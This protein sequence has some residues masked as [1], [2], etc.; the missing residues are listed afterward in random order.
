VVAQKQKEEGA[1]R[2]KLVLLG[3][4]GMVTFFAG[5]WVTTARGE[6]IEKDLASMCAALD[7]AYKKRSWGKD[8]CNQIEWIEGGKSVKGRPLIYA[9]FGPKDSKNV[10]LIL[11]MVHG[12]EITPLYIGFEMAAWAKKEMSRYPQARLI[13]APLVN[14]DGFLDYPKTRVN[15]NGVDCNRNFATADWEK[16]ALKSWK[17]KFASN[18]R[19]FPGHKP[20][21][22]PETLFQKMLIEKFKPN[23]IVSV[24]SPLNVIDY[25]GPDH[26][27]LAEFN[28]EYIKKCQELR[29]AVKA[30]STGFF[31]GSLGNYSGV[32]LGIPTITL[33]LPTAEFQHAKK[34][35][36][37]W[38]SGMELV[39]RHEVPEK[40]PKK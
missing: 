19:R 21:S 36:N 29:I 8:P 32:E 2:V 11:S 7:G 5:G 1:A 4:V 17:K 33:E 23:K 14:P 30:Q 6:N 37:L 3:W 12:D 16:D 28:D 18:P 24:H 34:Y 25:D 26:L 38:K 20:D 31:P 13:I 9:D 15:A 22:E 39:V 10:T 35:W 40:E 27:K